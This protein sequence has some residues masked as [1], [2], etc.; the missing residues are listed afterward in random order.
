MQKRNGGEGFQKIKL[1]LLLFHSS[2]FP[3]QIEELT[4]ITVLHAENEVVFSLKTAV[5]LSDKGVIGTSLENRPLVIHDIL[6]LVLNDEL[7]IDDFQCH[8]F[9]VASRQIHLRETSSSHTFNYI[10]TAQ[11]ALMFWD[12][13]FGWI[14]L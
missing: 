9:S 8:N 13:N 4:S 2:D 7:F 5:E 11:R 3:Q 10:E 12:S 14:N 1:S 6:L